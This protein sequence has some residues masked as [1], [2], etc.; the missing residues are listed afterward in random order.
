M[1]ERIRLEAEDFDHLVRGGELQTDDGTCI[2]LADVGFDRVIAIA[3]GVP[4]QPSM[5]GR[6]RAV[7]G[8]LKQSG[9][10]IPTHAENMAAFNK[11]LDAWYKHD[12]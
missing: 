2:I 10:R 9:A 7:N 1:S 4:L 12:R 11:A 3:N 6:I 8:S 5:L